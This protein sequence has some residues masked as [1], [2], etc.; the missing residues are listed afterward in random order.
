MAKSLLSARQT[1]CSQNVLPHSKEMKCKELFFGLIFIL[2]MVIR[3]NCDK[4][5][6]RI[7]KTGR[8][9]NQ[10]QPIILGVFMLMNIYL[11]FY[12]V[13]AISHFYGFVRKCM[14]SRDIMTIRKNF[15]LRLVG[16][17]I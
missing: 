2:L 17:E 3:N 12:I 9:T 7:M 5:Q 6:R 13:R 16:G 11:C 15:E 8:I 1:L 10:V 14:G 4:L